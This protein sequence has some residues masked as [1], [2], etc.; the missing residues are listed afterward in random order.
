MVSKAKQELVE[1]RLITVQKERGPHGDYD[2]I[3][4]VDIW[5]ENKRSYSERMSSQ[6]EPKRSPGETK[7]IPATRGPVSKSQKDATTRV[8]PVSREKTPRERNAPS[9]SRQTS[10]HPALEAV[11]QVSGYYPRRNLF[12]R[13][14]EIVGDTPDIS[15]LQAAYDTWTANGFNPLNLKGWLF[16]W[17]QEG[18]H[19]LTPS[20]V[21]D[22]E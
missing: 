11:K 13:V 3:T 1:A 7:N 16:D 17:Y 6:D 18:M 12:K 5:E 15:R 21:L 14:I 22:P 10:K 8:S 19:Y 20:Q 2:L 9:S 4:I